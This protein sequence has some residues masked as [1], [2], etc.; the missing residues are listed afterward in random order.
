M[1]R[2]ERLQHLL[3][4]ADPE[5]LALVSSSSAGADASDATGDDSRHGGGHDVVDDIALT[6]GLAALLATGVRAQ[7]FL[8]RM[9]RGRTATSDDRPHPPAG[10]DGKTPNDPPTQKDLVD[11]AILYVVRRHR[12]PKDQLSF[13]SIS[14][15]DESQAW[16]VSLAYARGGV[17]DVAIKSVNND[18][19]P[20]HSELLQAD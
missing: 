4:Q 12:V 10:A 8:R 14:Y 16:L 20:C 6:G 1:E 7:K 5:V 19:I 15:H 13:D 9:Q 11:L 18:C 17:Y 2:S 3:S